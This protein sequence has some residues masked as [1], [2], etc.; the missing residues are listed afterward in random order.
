MDTYAKNA[1]GRGYPLH[2]HFIV[3]D[4]D[5]DEVVPE[6]VAARL[7]HNTGAGDPVAAH[8]HMQ[9]L[10]RA[11][12]TRLR[13]ALDRFGFSEEDI[14]AMFA[15]ANTFGSPAV[16]NMFSDIL[17]RATAHHKPEDMNELAPLVRALQAFANHL[18]FT[19]HDELPMSEFLAEAA[20][21][22]ELYGRHVPKD[23]SAYLA[24]VRASHAAIETALK[25]ARAQEER[26]QKEVLRNIAE[27]GHDDNMAD[28]LRKTFAEANR[29]RDTRHTVFACAAHHALDWYFQTEAW[30][31][32]RRTPEQ[33]AALALYF[34]SEYSY[35]RGRYSTVF[36]A[37]DLSRFAGWKSSS[38]LAN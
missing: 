3:D 33:L 25:E 18:C 24:L 23:W 10:E 12:R 38:S 21:N 19:M 27:S 35:S 37:T 20:T 7:W 31:A 5:M 29:E 13:A 14:R 1:K 8:E 34:V 32:Y 16:R 9:I 22:R 4:E 26:S 11:A 17:L 2:E 28:D 36:Y 15:T 6:E 30:N